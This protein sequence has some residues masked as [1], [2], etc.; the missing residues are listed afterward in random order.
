[1][2]NVNAD[3]DELCNPQAFNKMDETA[4]KQRNKTKSKKQNKKT[5]K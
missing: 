4:Q 2:I 3:N 5:K 1:M